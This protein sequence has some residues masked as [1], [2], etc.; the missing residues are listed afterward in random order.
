MGISDSEEK[1]IQT[2][3]VN[4]RKFYDYLNEFI[5]LIFFFKVYIRVIYDK[6]QHLNNSKRAVSISTKS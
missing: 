4:M 6:N 1:V 5:L 2:S 3:S